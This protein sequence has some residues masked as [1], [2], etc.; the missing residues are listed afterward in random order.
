MQEGHPMGP[1]AELQASYFEALRLKGR[2]D[3]TIERCTAILNVFGRFLEFIEV[4]HPSE[5]TDEIIMRFQVDLF[6]RKS[7]R[8]KEYAAR[9]KAGYLKV[10]RNFFQHCAAKGL[11]A[12]DPSKAFLVPKERKGIPKSILSVEEVERLLAIPN[13]KTILGF[14]D[15]T[16]MEVLY[17]T[18]IRSQELRKLTI[19]DI[20][21][22]SGMVRIL[23][24]KNRQDRVVPIGR[25][26]QGFLTEYIERVRPKIIDYAAT[27]DYGKFRT[28]HPATECDEG[29]LFISRFGGSLSIYGLWKVIVMCGKKSGIVKPITPHILRHSMATH[30]LEAGMDIRHIQEL[31]GHKSLD[32]TQIYARVSIGELKRLYRKF[33]P[34]ERRIRKP[35]EPQSGARPSWQL[36]PSVAAIATPG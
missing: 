28:K 25:L 20:D 1:L 14:R 11:L 26:A 4:R 21:F 34:K 23:F 5:I 33:H 19:D 3:G 24:A 17:S 10:L 30:L 16:M 7:R 18:G 12:G 15:R 29:L 2:K 8:H 9:S 31:L 35:T 27:T 32:T 22:D 6:E 13:T 36:Q